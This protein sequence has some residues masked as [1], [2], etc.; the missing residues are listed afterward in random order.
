MNAFEYEN[1]TE[2]AGFK[3]G[4]AAIIGRPNVGKSTL[5]NRLTGEKIAIVSNKPQTTR[6]QIQGV[7]TGE[8]FQAVFIDTPGI[9]NAKNK[10]GGFMVRT[11]E[12]AL[13]ETDIVILITEADARGVEPDSEIIG[14]LTKL[15]N[16]FLVLNKADKIQKAAILETIDKYKNLFPFKE[17]IPISALTGENCGA[18]LDAIKNNLPEGPRYF[19]DDYLTDRPEKFIISEII[20]EKAL[21]YLQEEIPHGIAVETEVREKKNIFEVSAVIFCEKDSHK[22]IIIGKNGALLKKIGET[23]RAEIER[24]LGTK[25]FLETWVKVKK[26]WRDDDFMLKSLGYGKRGR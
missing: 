20:R 13:G 1:L 15:K 4:F 21:L 6:N 25:I 2:D 24:L 19:P 5:M 9:H 17:I 14:R 12:A 11:A 26:N 23:S 8:G 22:G 3:S 18:L 16:V 7:L 10:L